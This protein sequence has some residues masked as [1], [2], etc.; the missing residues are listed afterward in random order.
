MIDLGKSI[1]AAHE[2]VAK[3][4]SAIIL[5][6]ISSADDNIQAPVLRRALVLLS[7][8]HGTSG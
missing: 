4:L 1:K 3:Q 8:G 5:Y 7:Q 2:S 6:L